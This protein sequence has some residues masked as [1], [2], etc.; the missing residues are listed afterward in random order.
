MSTAAVVETPSGKNETTENFPVGSWLL[1][2]ELRPHIAKFY[3]F[4]RAIDDIADNPELTAKTKIDR[5][6]AMDDAVCGATTYGQPGYET[7]SELHDSLKETGITTRH[8]SDLVDAFRQDALKN[9]Y[10]DWD[11]L[12]G[13]CMRSA[14]PVGRYL[15]DLHGEDRSGYPYSDALCNALQVINHLQDC[16]DDYLE[17]DRVYLPNVWLKQHDTGVSALSAAKASWQLRAVIDTCLDASAELMKTAN[18][19]PG[20]LKN[21]R[22][23]ME[24][25]VI[26]NIANKLIAELRARDPLAERVKLS[27]GQLARGTLSGIVS[28]WFGRL[29]G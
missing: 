5:L 25:A 10:D 21:R 9:R 20:R 29:Q 28:G 2:A 4:A 23:A 15:L 17:M 8:C 19:L 18:Q 6:N 13:Y 24:S 11:D 3:R 26:V 16:K 22:L 1:P 7:A 27:K 12:I 14:A